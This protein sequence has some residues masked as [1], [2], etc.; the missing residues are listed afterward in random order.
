MDSDA[1][2]IVSAYK[3]FDPLILWPQLRS[4]NRADIQ[5]RMDEE[6]CGPVVLQG[7]LQRMYGKPIQELEYYKEN[8][9]E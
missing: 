5:R 7:C 8:S 9:D 3:I 4:F 1:V 2:H 6:G